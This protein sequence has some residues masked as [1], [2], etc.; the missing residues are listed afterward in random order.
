MKSEV[1]FARDRVPQ[2]DESG[3]LSNGFSNHSN[4]ED[5]PLLSSNYGHSDSP[6]ISNSSSVHIYQPNQKGRLGN[7]P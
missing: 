4:G 6:N 3:L 1:E 7:V 5:A 2:S